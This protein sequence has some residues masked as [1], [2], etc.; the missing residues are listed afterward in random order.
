[1]RKEHITVIVGKHAYNRIVERLNIKSPVLEQIIET[2]NNIQPWYLKESRN[3][4]NEYFLSC[5]QISG[6]FVLSFNEKDYYYFAKTFETY[7]RTEGK[8]AITN[9]LWYK[10]IKVQR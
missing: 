8:P 4:Y 10:E 3:I 9:F 2:L 7:P 5:P 6:S 1:V